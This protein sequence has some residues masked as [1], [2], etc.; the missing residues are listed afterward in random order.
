MITG[1]EN[2]FLCGEQGEVDYPALARLGFAGCDYQQ[3]SKY[4]DPL[5]ALEEE[6]FQ[7]ELC[8]QKQQAE[9]AGIRFT[10]V[11]GLWPMDDTTAEKRKISLELYKKCVRGCHYLGSSNLVVHPILPR[12]FHKAENAGEVERVNRE[13]ITEL[14][15]YARKFQVNL[16]ME[17]MP[18]EVP[19]LTPLENLVK[20]V[21]SLE[22]P[23][24]KL[25]LD[26]GHENMWGMDAGD[27]VRMCGSLLQVL[28]IHDNMGNDDSHWIPWLGTVDWAH[29]V[30][31]LKDIGF[32]G[33][34]SLECTLRP[35]PQEL[36]PVM[37]ELAAQAGQLLLQNAKG[38]FL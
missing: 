4:Q 15:L 21:R 1:I 30:Q 33:C 26:T 12:D 8:R 20:F 19:G 27:A 22:L 24:G 7:A 11:H 18:F 16:C 10:Q 6:A 17:N 23:N 2:T 34:L 38:V 31:G 36:R 14:A 28:H 35:Y 32:D 37:A 5:Y 13:Y 29:F 9:A 25:C 3:L